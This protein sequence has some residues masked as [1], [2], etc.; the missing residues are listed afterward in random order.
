MINLKQCYHEMWFL[1]DSNA[2][3]TY[4]MY[5]PLFHRWYICIPV[6]HGSY[7]LY[8]IVP[9]MVLSI[10]QCAIDLIIYIPLFHR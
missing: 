3:F 5:M 8:N 10:Y 1:L 6:F 9:Q 2:R 7:C 4:I